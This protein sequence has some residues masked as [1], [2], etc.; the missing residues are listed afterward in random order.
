VEDWRLT[1]Q[2]DADGV[3][4]IIARLREREVEAEARK[5]LGAAVAVSADGDRLFAYADSREAIHEAKRIVEELLAEHDLSAELAVDRW[6][7]L[8]ERWE[9]ED[10]PL[11]GTDAERRAEHERLES[12]EAAESQREGRAQWEVRLE[13]PSHGGARELADVLERE[14][15][16]VERR[17]RYLLVGAENE[18]EAH[19]LAER[20]RTELPPDAIV[21]VEAGEAMAED[22]APPNPFAFFGGLAG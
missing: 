21:S 4:R 20:L 2:L 19:A 14:G 12:D 1:A 16:V 15:L 10:V 5:R 8:E 11:P 18:D 3:E 6:H 9:D 17:W 13:L 7:E 22:V